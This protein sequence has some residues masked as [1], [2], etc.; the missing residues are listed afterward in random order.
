MMETAMR[1]AGLI[2]SIMV[3]GFTGTLFLASGGAGGH[4]LTVRPA[5]DDQPI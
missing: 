3:L 4:S 1:W 5:V 2:L